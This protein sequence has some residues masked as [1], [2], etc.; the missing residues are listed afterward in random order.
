MDSSRLAFVHWNASTASALSP[1]MEAD[2]SIG[3]FNNS[4]FTI[5][6]GC[7]VSVNTNITLQLSS[8]FVLR[9]VENIYLVSNSVR[10][11][12]V[13][14]HNQCLIVHFINIGESAFSIARGVLLF[15]VFVDRRTH[16]LLV[17]D[18]TL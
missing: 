15:K 3:F 14:A 18:W 10:V 6:P 5:R 12:F 4:S 9:S 1:S 8:N 16:A 17:E 7:M 11:L 13:T 2:G